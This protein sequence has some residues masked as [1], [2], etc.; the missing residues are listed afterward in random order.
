VYESPATR[1]VATFM[2]DADFLPVHTVEAGLTSEIGV[3][4]TVRREGRAESG[5]EVMLRPHDV[6]LTADTGSPAVVERLEYHGPFVLHVVR[7]GSGRTVRSWQYHGVRH[8]VGTRVAVSMVPRARP[9]ILAADT[10]APR[11]AG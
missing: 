7:L 5:L 8:P 4:S 3:V 9:V 2:G 10:A 1:F 6:A 11:P